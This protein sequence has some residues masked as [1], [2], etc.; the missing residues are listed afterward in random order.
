MNPHASKSRRLGTMNTD[1]TSKIPFQMSMD[2]QSN[3]IPRMGPVV[4]HELYFPQCYPPPFN[5]PFGGAQQH[6]GSG[7]QTPVPSSGPPPTV[8]Q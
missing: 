5:Q 3:L 7:T 8:V 1:G 2:K 4:K 6:A